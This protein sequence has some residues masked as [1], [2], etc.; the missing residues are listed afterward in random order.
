MAAAA[1]VRG[2]CGGTYDAAAALDGSL[3]VRTSTPYSSTAVVRIVLTVTHY[4]APTAV[5]DL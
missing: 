1:A 4:G 2:G 5:L 3:A